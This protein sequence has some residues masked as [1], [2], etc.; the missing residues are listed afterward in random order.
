VSGRRPAAIVAGAVAVAV[1]L[2]LVGRWERDRRAGEEIRGMESV[3]AAV[4]PLDSPSLSAFR[5]LKNFQCLLYRRDGNRVALELCFDT[6]G[7]LVEAMD[8]RF[9]DPR[10]WSLRDDPEL[11]TIRVDRTEVDRQLLRMGVPQRLIDAAYA[12]GGS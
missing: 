6:E 8:R 7:R 5:Y 11:S 4:G 12:E 2:V 9:G 1:L 10:I 3:L